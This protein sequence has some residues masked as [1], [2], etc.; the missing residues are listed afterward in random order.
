MTKIA[1]NGGI[2]TLFVPCSCSGNWERS[3]I[4]TVDNAVGETRSAAVDADRKIR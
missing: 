2:V 3:I 1:Y 4:Q